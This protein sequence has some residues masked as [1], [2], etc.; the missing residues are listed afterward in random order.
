MT[1]KDWTQLGLQTISD[2]CS[3]LKLGRKKVRSTGNR[4]GLNRNRTAQQLSAVKRAGL[5]L[6]VWWYLHSIGEQPQL[7]DLPTIT[8]H[9][10]IICQCTNWSEWSS[11]FF[12]LLLVSLEKCKVRGKNRETESRTTG[13]KC[14]MPEQCQC[15][16]VSTLEQCYFSPIYS[17]WTHIDTHTNTLISAAYQTR[18]LPNWSRQKPGAQMICRINGPSGTQTDTNSS[19]LQANVNSITDSFAGAGV[20]MC[21]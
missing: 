10:N 3:L 4:S 13:Q 5:L 17:K 12:F 11:F 15:Q 2:G 20:I 16:P 6:S 21:R 18:V 9:L 7:Q 1:P 8:E 19:R 14:A